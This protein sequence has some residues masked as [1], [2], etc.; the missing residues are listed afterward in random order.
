MKRSTSASLV[1]RDKLARQG[2]LKL[3]IR[4]AVLA[5]VRVR[6]APERGRIFARPGRHLADA[7]RFDRAVLLDIG[8]APLAR[9]VVGVIG[10][11]ALRSRLDAAVIVRHELSRSARRRKV[12]RTRTP[13]KREKDTTPK[14]TRRALL[15]SPPLLF[16]RTFLGASPRNIKCASP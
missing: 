9:N 6:G 14:T 4:V 15:S 2:E 12:G 16:S 5:L 13:E 7:L 8:K 11:R 10:G 1:T 3:P